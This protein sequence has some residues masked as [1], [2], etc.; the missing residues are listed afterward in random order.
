[1]GDST[2]Q[3]GYGQSA[4]RFAAEAAARQAAEAAKL[5]AAKQ[6]ALQRQA[7]AAKG[8]PLVRD[9]FE[10]PRT[11]GGVNLSGGNAPST[12]GFAR[13]EGGNGSSGIPAT[14]PLTVPQAQAE[15]KRLLSSN[16][17]DDVTHDDLMGIQAVLGR[18]PADQVNSVVAGLSDAELEQWV[19]DLNDPG[20]AGGGPFRG[21]STEERGE[22]FTFLADNLEPAQAGR[23]FT[24]LDSPEQMVEFGESFIQRGDVHD[25]L[26]F[27]MAV[28]ETSFPDS[29]R[30]ASGQ[31]LASAM[32]ALTSDPGRLAIGVRAL[33]EQNLQDGLLK[34]AGPAW[35]GMGPLG[36]QL[37]YTDLGRLQR[38]TGAVA[39]TEDHQARAAMFDGMG[40]VLGDMVRGQHAVQDKEAVA[41]QVSGMMTNLLSDDL[42][43]VLTHLSGANGYDPTGSSFTTYAR[44]QMLDEGGALSDLAGQMGELNLHSPGP[45]GR[46]DTAFVAGYF[47]GSVIRAAD[48]LTAAELLGPDKAFALELA[49]LVVSF[50]TDPATGT[51]LSGAMSAA[52]QASVEKALS[53]G[54]GSVRN[55]VLDLLGMELSPGNDNGTPLGA[56]EQGLFA[57]YGAALYD[58]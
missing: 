26:G 57:V 4:A 31:V 16:A 18:V 58:P 39:S 55:A 15:V 34:A 40:F 2:I 23:V 47:A 7:P 9:T 54:A 5:E 13:W 28:G 41:D 19:E 11:R 53:E 48:S 14:G 10:A 6:A 45:N 29:E 21:L 1:M 22:L 42:G 27:L 46:Y 49:K 32:D 37:Q 52:E 36:G 56:F 43:M 51:L 50:R 30:A 17:L 38:I 3:P 25:R 8:Q 33:S 24:A 35:N 12:T 44:E 20:L